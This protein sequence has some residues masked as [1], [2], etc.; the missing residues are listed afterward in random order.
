LSQDRTFI[1]DL[2][3]ECWVAHSGEAGYLIIH[4]G[5]S[6][7]YLGYYSDECRA[8]KVLAEIFNHYKNQDE[9]Y[10]MPIE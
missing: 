10:E 5:Y 6:H 4:T 7:P 9:T 1:T 2:G 8:K 3:R